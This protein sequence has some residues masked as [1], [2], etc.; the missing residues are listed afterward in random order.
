MCVWGKGQGDYKVETL[1]YKKM[2]AISVL[3][4][5]ALVAKLP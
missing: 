1:K 2:I 5:S 4:S 3:T